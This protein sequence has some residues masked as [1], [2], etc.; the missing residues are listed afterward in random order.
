MPWGTKRRRHE[1]LCSP[2]LS[3][4]RGDAIKTYQ[5]TRTPPEDGGPLAQVSDHAAVHILFFFSRW[6]GLREH[7]S[8]LLLRHGTP[9]PKLDA[10]SVYKAC[11][12][13]RFVLV[14]HTRC[15]RAEAWC[16]LHDQGPAEARCSLLTGPA[17]AE[18]WCELHILGLPQLGARCTTKACPSLVL[19]TQSRPADAEAWCMW[20]IMAKANLSHYSYERCSLIMNARASR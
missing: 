16:S 18:T 13:R 3:T 9:M 2:T 4:S 12:C 17:D 19:V 7:V 10:C 20:N 8:C 5:G 6:F 15:A 11:R 14:T 1:A